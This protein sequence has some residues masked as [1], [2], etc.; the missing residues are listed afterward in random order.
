[1][2]RFKFIARHDKLVADYIADEPVY[3]SEIFRR[4]FRMSRAL[5]LRIAGDMA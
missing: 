5:F 1:M 3:P 2:F 4:R